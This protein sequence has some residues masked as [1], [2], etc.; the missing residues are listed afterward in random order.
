MKQ[1]IKE[2]K[3]DVKKYLLTV[4]LNGFELTFLFFVQILIVMYAI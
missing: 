3:L 2:I 1:L 4:N